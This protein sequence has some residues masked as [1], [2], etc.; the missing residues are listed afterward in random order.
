[1]ERRLSLPSCRARVTAVAAAS[2]SNPGPGCSSS[3]ARSSSH[4]SA[5]GHI[6]PHRNHEADINS[7]ITH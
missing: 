7:L 6:S 1:M 2:S 5:T 3:S 4:E